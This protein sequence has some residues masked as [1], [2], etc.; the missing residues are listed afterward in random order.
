[1]L[2][3]KGPFWALLVGLCVPYALVGCDDDP[4]PTT[5]HDEPST[6][7]CSE[8]ADCDDGNFCN[9]NERCVGSAEGAAG[10]GG[11]ASRCEAGEDPCKLG[12]TCDDEARKCTTD[13]S[14][15]HDADGDG[16]DALE[17]SGDDCDDSDANRY[18]TNAEVC[19]AGGHDEDCDSATIG[20]LD[21]DGDGFIADS[22][23][24]TDDSGGE[25]CGEDCNDARRNVH[26]NASEVCDHFDN[27]CNGEIDEELQVSGF[28][29]LDADLYGDPSKKT[30]GCPGDSGFVET[31]GDCD[32][33]NPQANAGLGEAC[34]G[35]DNDCNPNTTDGTDGS[36]QPWYQDADGDGYGE[37]NSA[38]IVSCESPSKV[39]VKYSLAAGDCADTDASVSPRAA[40]LCN[41]RDDN[42]DGKA[43]FVVG[44]GDF[45]DDDGDGSPDAACGG[46]DCDDEDWR[47][48]PDAPEVADGRDN[49]CDGEI[50][51]EVTPAL[52]Y[53]DSDGDEYGDPA[54][55]QESTTPLAGYV[56]RAGD[57]RPNDPA[58]YPGAT[59]LCDN[60]D[61]NCN[62]EVD[63]GLT[64]QLFPDADGDGYGNAA[65][66]AVEA[67]V[68]P[69]GLVNDA[70]DCDD[71]VVTSRPGAPELCGDLVDSDCNGR[72]DDAICESNA[73]LSFVA[74]QGGHIEPEFSPDVTTY[75]LKRSFDWAGVYLTPHCMGAASGTCAIVDG[76]ILT[77]SQKSV[78]KTTTDSIQIQG[79]NGAAYTFNVERQSCVLEKL[80]STDA[81]AGGSFGAALGANGKELVVGAPRRDSD[82]GAS[83]AGAAYY[84]ERAYDGTFRQVGTLKPPYS[85]D[86]DLTGGAVAVGNGVI[87]VSSRGDDAEFNLPLSDNSKDGV[88]A[89]HV[90]VRSAGVY[91]YSK[92]LRPTVAAK[93]AFGRAL[94]I[95]RATNAIA[96]GQPTRA[97]VFDP[98]TY[99]TPKE[100][101]GTANATYAT[102]LGLG[103][104]GLVVSDF[105]TGNN[106]GTLYFHKR[107]A[108]GQAFAAAGSSDSFQLGAWDNFGTAVAADGNTAVGFSKE[109][110]WISGIFTSDPGLGPNGGA[111][112]AGPERDYGGVYVYTTSGSAYSFTHYIKSPSPACKDGF[113]MGLALRDDLLLV[114][115]PYEGTAGTGV[116]F[117]ARP[118]GTGLASSGGV[119]L[120][121]RHGANWY[122]LAHLKSA[123]PVASALQGAS[124]TIGDHFLAFGPNSGGTDGGKD[125]ASPLMGEVWTCRWE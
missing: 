63:E 6:S 73:V 35:V 52:W 20:E 2:S 56:Q 7:E 81:K 57:C 104:N 14:V 33:D 85:D 110:G 118:N 19:D 106:D 53:E 112:C 95:D 75:T 54:S 46:D 55:V 42:C 97:Y 89:V 21:V 105:W 91:G 45:E 5:S 62:G 125:P 37:L 12:Q 76:A 117:T 43:N 18:P 102:A 25:K 49:D 36:E 101:P 67:C 99:G 65:A 40:E 59:E 10:A 79:P 48:R 31:A 109:E 41:G 88:G 70:S 122:L 74:V 77:E 114:G 38:P 83:D 27:D 29:D 13:C 115:A 17:C 96:V 24:N 30:K 84:F 92:S 51:E 71:D 120:Y 22:C 28:I 58:S 47:T 94:A 93:T 44:P 69:T 111:G 78:L 39:G 32:D 34:D 4:G 60:I 61:Q 15:T 50:D 23:C 107:S 68:V 16:H 11:A 82:T 66:H 103:N 64:K 124:V 72:I 90:F 116:S 9:G 123:A 119:Y 3:H 80:V 1:M 121:R 8:D 98:P 26:P 113:G 87:A 108:V 86:G 100:L